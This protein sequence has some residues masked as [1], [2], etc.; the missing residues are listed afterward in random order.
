MSAD[1]FPHLALAALTLNVA[2]FALFGLDKAL[3][4]RRR[5]RIAERR[6]LT[7]ALIGGT[8]GAYA[9]RALFRHKTRKQPFVARLHGIAALQVAALAGWVWFYGP[10]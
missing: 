1:L 5:R 10:A 6:L 9:A 4:T 3:A 8:P 7:L 2:T